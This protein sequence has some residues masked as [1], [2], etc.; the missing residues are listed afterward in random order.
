MYVP[1]MRE[2]E[3]MSDE[4]AVTKKPSPWANNGGARPG[5]GRKPGPGYNAQIRQISKRHTQRVI[6]AARLRG[7]RL[8]PRCVEVLKEILN[9]PKATKPELLR[10]VE[11][12]CD[13]FGL[14]VQ[15]NVSLAAEGI[16]PDMLADAVIRASE[17][18][19]VEPDEGEVR[20]ICADFE[21]IKPGGNGE[22]AGTVQ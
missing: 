3:A 5:A 16:T 11:I 8:L 15:R 12:A 20:A 21:V 18:I 14:P 4:L 6:E 2:A 10:A 7:V 1:R 13:R 22:P 17:R 19:A 9:D